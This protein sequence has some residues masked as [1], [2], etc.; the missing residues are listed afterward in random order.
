MPDVI[1]NFS[2]G[3]G[4]SLTIEERVSCLDADPEMASLNMGTLMRQSGPN[5]GS[6]SST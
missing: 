1:V 2:T 6:H 5:A 3:G 4:A